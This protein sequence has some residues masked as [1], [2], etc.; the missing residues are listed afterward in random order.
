[1]AGVVALL[2]LLLVANAGAPTTDR[3]G[4]PGPAVLFHPAVPGPSPGP[5]PVGPP[6]PHPTW[7]NVT[8]TTPH[9]APPAAV[10][11]A[12]AYDP[13]TNQ[14]VAFGGCVSGGACPD[15]QTWVFADGVWANVTD[16]TDAPPAR[17]YAAMDYD[18]N[19][20][21]ILLFGGYGKSGP[22]NDTWTYRDGVWTNVTF[23]SVAP[24]AREAASL[25][26]DP[27][28]EE[29]GS[30]LFGGCI[31]EFIF[32]ACDN[33]TWVW[34]GDA[35]WVQL[36]V[37]VAPPFRGW[38]MMAYDASD[39]YVVLFGGTN[40]LLGIL[41]DTWE[42]YAGQWWNVTPKNSPPADATGGMVYD[43]ALPGLVLFGGFNDSAVYVASTWKFLGGVWTEQSPAASPPA[44]GDFVFALDATGTTPIVEGGENA[45]TAYQDTWAYEYA[46]ALVIYTNVSGGE[47][48]ESVQVQLVVS[49][50]TAPYSLAVGFGDGTSVHLTGPGSTT[51]VPHVY[52]ATGTF[53]I[54]ATATDAVGSTFSASTVD[55]GV[56]A[57][58]AVRAEARPAATDVGVSVAFASTVL[59]NGTLPLAYDW[60]FG[61]G[62]GSS[63][64]DPTHAYASPG[65]YRVTLNAT[66]HVGAVSSSSFLVTVAP[67]PTVSAS[68]APSTPDRGVVT[69]FF[70]NVSG[71]TGPYS[72]SWR[73]GDG[74]GSL[75]P[76]P[77]HW[78]N[79][80]GTY[81]I[82]V[83][84]NDS[85]GEDAHASW[86]LTVP[87]A[88]PFWGSLSG[89]PPWFW[90][91]LGAIGA[92]GAGGSAFLLRRGRARP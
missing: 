37:S 8:N 87:S 44:R 66:D 27:Q 82:N 14:T 83:W 41:D 50:G 79:S 54:S 72:F 81:R 18:A 51:D 65:T 70:A 22:L 7:V 78:F 46:P 76:S 80:T 77:Q 53:P 49:G 62:L 1:M 6:S 48:G 86:T 38:A 16:H 75:L 5:D 17:D 85:A 39:G 55:F 57:G 33:D 71:G 9:A 31:P 34:Q 42:L 24:P 32:D 89:A 25:A 28:P 21:A 68:A 29:N 19:M 4:G 74:S 52:A 56:S 63:L 23:Y 60:S 40:G 90:G 88:T 73:F 20:Q 91:G 2:A 30:V 67:D 69:A 43:P 15:N 58:P 35:G 12:S 13:L 92:V 45:T 47:V 64:A 10:G 59:T 11:A 3:S 61:D 26:F 36:N 84:V